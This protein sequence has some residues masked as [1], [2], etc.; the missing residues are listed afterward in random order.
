MDS[1]LI[2]AQRASPTAILALTILIIGF[3]LYQLFVGKMTLKISKTQD[4]K[5]PEIRSRET[6]HYENVK[7][8]IEQNNTLLN[9]HFKHEIPEILEG[10]KANKEIIERVEGT[11]NEIKQDLKQHSERITRI[12]TL[13]QVIR[14]K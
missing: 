9:N 14:E 2:F 12:E 11:V 1:F 4:E 10:Q 6:Q 5:Y 13:V 3:I 7:Q 8:L